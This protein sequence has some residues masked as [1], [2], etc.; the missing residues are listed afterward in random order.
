MKLLL[1][2]VWEKKGVALLF[3]FYKVFRFRVALHLLEYYTL[4][5][6]NLIQFYKTVLVLAN[7]IIFSVHVVLA[8][9]SFH[10]E[11]FF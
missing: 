6:I 8:K 4:N 11:A 9:E 10:L 3:W 7:F 1:L 2:D 5:I